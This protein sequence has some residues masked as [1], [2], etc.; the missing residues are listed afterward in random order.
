[1]ETYVVTHHVETVEGKCDIEREIKM[2]VENVIKLEEIKAHMMY[3]VVFENEHELQVSHE[4]GCAEDI[5]E[6]MKMFVNEDWEN[7]FSDYYDPMDFEY[8]YFNGVSFVSNGK[9]RIGMQI[10]GN[11]K[12][13][14][15]NLD[16]ESL[17]DKN[18]DKLKRIREIA[19]ED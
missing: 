6:Q 12:Q 9:N 18:A 16:I 19:N 17:A 1:M 3:T 14:S 4:V 10:Y 8:A 2:A 5:E 15:C 13:G 11:Y 7:L